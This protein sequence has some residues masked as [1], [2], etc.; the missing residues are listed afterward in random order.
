MSSPV[1]FFPLPCSC[2]SSSAASEVPPDR[3]P[4]SR[5]CTI[6]PTRFLSPCPSL[7]LCPLPLPAH[8]SRLR[9]SPA[10]CTHPVALLDC[11]IM[12]FLGNACCTYTTVKVVRFT[13]HARIRNFY[14]AIVFLLFLYTI[15]YKVLWKF[16]VRSLWMGRKH[17]AVFPVFCFCAQLSL[18]VWADDR[19]SREMMC[20][21]AILKP[22]GGCAYGI[23]LEGRTCKGEK[24]E[25]S[26]QRGL[27]E[28]QRGEEEGDCRHL[29]ARVDPP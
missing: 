19:E 11:P 20:E 7:S 28:R 21:K 29:G 17:V 15:V 13:Q 27:R 8:P 12:Q 26:G 10:H 14:L 24:S 22:S 1:Y 2:Y 9:S 3:P 25:E 16:Q 23:Y 4:S 6:L 18:V 5:K